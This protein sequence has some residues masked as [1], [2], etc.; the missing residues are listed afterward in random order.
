M[1]ILI[2]FEDGRVAIFPQ[3]N[4]ELQG[5]SI[6]NA[7]APEKNFVMSIPLPVL[8]ENLQAIN[9]FDAVLMELGDCG[10][11]YEVYNY[12]SEQD[13]KGKLIFFDSGAVLCAFEW[14]PHHRQVMKT[15]V[16]RATVIIQGTAFPIQPYLNLLGCKTP[17]A[18]DI[19]MPVPEE[20]VLPLKPRHSDI[21]LL[22]GPFSFEGSGQ[23]PLGVCAMLQKAGIKHD[24]IGRA[25]E[26]FPNIQ[27]R[28][29]VSGE[30][31][32]SLA[33]EYFCLVQPGMGRP[34]GGRTAL[35]AA[36]V[37]IV[38][39]S[40]P[41]PPQYA[42]YP[43][44]IFHWNEIEKIPELIEKILMEYDDIIRRARDI[45][46][47]EYTIPAIQKKLEQYL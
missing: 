41:S 11:G 36:S 46:L 43:D 37:G 45:L 20:T 21:V 38:S 6:G 25:I 14:Q 22:V 44:F 17:V 9:R 1:N 13:Y 24:I 32:P 23:L 31:F 5:I 30:A 18:F 28:N 3:R 16:E 39:F 2:S 7:L 8:R 34:S 4:L 29:G 47:Q 12:L 26:F 42:L 15:L 19:T 35:H 40:E 10:S 33:Q 27:P